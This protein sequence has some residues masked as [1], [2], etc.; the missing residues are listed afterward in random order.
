[1]WSICVM[2]HVRETALTWS[3]P[4]VDVETFASRQPVLADF[5]GTSW[6]KLESL[7]IALVAVVLNTAILEEGLL[8]TFK[9]MA[10]EASR[11]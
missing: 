11:F 1:M 6:Y 7:A 3:T 10:A 4:C 8:M 2:L 9:K 5:F